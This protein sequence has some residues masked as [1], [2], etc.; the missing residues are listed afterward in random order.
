[1]LG[2]P[3][4]IID[5]IPD[6]IIAFIRENNQQKN[7]LSYQGVHKYTIQN[8]CTDGIA[9]QEDMRVED[10]LAVFEQMPELFGVMVLS[11]EKIVG[12]VTK[13]KLGRALSGRY[14]FSLHQKK[15]ISSI[16]EN[17]FLTVDSMTAISQVSTAAMER[18]AECLYDFVV[19]TTNGKYVGVV[20]VKDLLEKTLEIAVATAKLQSPLTE[21]PGNRLIEEEIERTIH[22]ADKYTVVYFDL[23]NFKAFNDVYGFEKGDL[24]IK[25]LARVLKLN[26]SENDFVGHIGG[27]DF[28]T[29]FR[30]HDCE[31]ICARIVRDYTEC[32]YRYYSVQDREKGYIEA[33]GREG[34]R[35]YFPLLS[36]TAALADNREC[37]YRSVEEI[38]AILAARK[39]R[40]KNEKKRECRAAL[41]CVPSDK[42]A[43]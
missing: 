31:K 30:Q 38:T 22:R 26:T 32:V 21:L 35:E 36:V 27:D 20:T 7:R 43:V 8:I 9:L 14:G 13:D 19:V 5:Q 29:I 18:T 28:V 23:D 39:K 2:R 25:E 16:M 34:E 17:N 11:G 15:P 33:V 41:Y 6:N 1:M 37:S 4:E 10:V 3:G 40:A 42:G 24:A 12:I